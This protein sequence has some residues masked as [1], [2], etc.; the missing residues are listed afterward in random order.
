MQKQRAVIRIFKALTE[1]HSC[2]AY[3]KGHQ[4]VLKAFG[5]QMITS[6]NNKWVNNPGMYVIVA[7]SLDN[8][9]MMAGIRIQLARG[10]QRL[11]IEIATGE[12]DSRVYDLVK[13]YDDQGLTGEITALWNAR[14]HK[15]IGFSKLLIA[16]SS[17][18]LNQLKMTSILGLC[19]TRNLQTMTMNGGYCIESSIGNGGYFYYPKQNLIAWAIILK[20]PDVINLASPEIQDL[21]F[22]LRKRPIQNKIFKVEGDTLEIDFKL[23]IPDEDLFF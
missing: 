5:I 6:N 2:L 11:P 12:V 9:E 7:E 3:M 21:I 19:D 8:G 10:N 20:D 22:D 13:I 4:Q 16:A 15:G 17:S 1:P 14:K 23:K 18:V